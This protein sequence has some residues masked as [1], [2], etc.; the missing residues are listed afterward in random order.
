MKT[1]NKNTN[2][3]YPNL[4]QCILQLKKL[5][6]T[7]AGRMVGESSMCKPTITD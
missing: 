2:Q 7:I 6:Q 5:Q 1:K 3:T 4:F